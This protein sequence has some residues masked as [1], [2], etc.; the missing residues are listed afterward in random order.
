MMTE[1]DDLHVRERLRIDEPLQKDVSRRAARTALGGEEL[2]ELGVGVR[3]G[4]PRTGAIADSTPT[5]SSTAIR[6]CIP[7]F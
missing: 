5:T 4:V 1:P 7:L 2:D 3:A 6:V